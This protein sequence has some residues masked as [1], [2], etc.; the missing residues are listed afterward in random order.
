MF[1]HWNNF[2]RKLSTLDDLSRHFGRLCNDVEVSTNVSCGINNSRVNENDD[3]F[4]LSMDMP[5]VDSESLKVRF[6][7]QILSID[8]KRAEPE[9]NYKRS[10]RLP[11]T[12]DAEKLQA[13]LSN[14]VLT[15]T[16]PKAE[17]SKAREIPVDLS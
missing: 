12:V 8:G 6:E 10:Y 5:G 16:L 13:K 4:T 2:D 1:T 7:N 9:L 15:V 3:S 14:G 11:T 17:A